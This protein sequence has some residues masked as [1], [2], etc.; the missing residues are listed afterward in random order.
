MCRPFSRIG[1]IRGAD[2]LPL[3][4]S[5]HPTSA[6][7]GSDTSWLKACAVIVYFILFSYLNFFSTPTYNTKV[8]C[9]CTGWFHERG[10]QNASLVS[11]LL[12]SAKK[13]PTLGQ[14]PSPFSDHFQLGQSRG[15]VNL[16]GLG[17]RVIEGKG[18][19]C[20]TLVTLHIPF[21]KNFVFKTRTLC[22]IQ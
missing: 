18:P 14:G 4:M 7:S 3:Q 1:R 21:T 20:E 10:T 15:K 5:P 11:L 9:T 6:I 22:Y 13:L 17:V 2:T 12:A 16:Q 19:T 8:H